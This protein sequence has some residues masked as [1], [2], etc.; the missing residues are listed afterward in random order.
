MIGERCEEDPKDD[1]HRAQKARG[2]HQ[3]QELR[4]VADLRET[5]DHR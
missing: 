2:K 4:L 1:R 5:D 3:G